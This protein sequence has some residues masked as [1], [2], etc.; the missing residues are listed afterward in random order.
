MCR[1]TFEV[2]GN[3]TIGIQ[4]YEVYDSIVWVATNK[5]IK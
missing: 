5:I 1:Q 4:Q 2:I 3:F